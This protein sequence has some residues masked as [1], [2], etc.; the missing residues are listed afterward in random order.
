MESIHDSECNSDDK[1]TYNQ[2]TA[3]LNNLVVKYKKLITNYL[4]DHDVIKAHKTK[5]DVLQEERTNLLG[6]KLCFLSLDIIL[7]L[8]RI[9]LSLK[10]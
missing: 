4:R 1:F 7:S 8:R 2:K 9:M 5:I 10:K 6:K 3:F